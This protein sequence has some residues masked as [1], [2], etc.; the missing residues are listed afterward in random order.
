MRLAVLALLL[1]ACSSE[2]GAGGDATFPAD[3]ITSARSDSGALTL[4][5]RTAPSQPPPRGTCTVEL[6]IT[7]ATGAPKDGLVLDVVPWMPAHGHGASVRP[8]VVAKGGGKYVATD[9]DLFM[10][11]EWELR[12]D[13]SG[14]TTDHAAPQITVP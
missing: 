14:S 1:A 7:D 11:G 12:T 8:S 3:P 2:S 6:T 9:V 10:P 4:V 5:V 13:V